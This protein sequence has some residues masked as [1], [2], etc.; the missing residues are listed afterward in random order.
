MAASEGPLID[1]AALEAHV[2]MLTNT[3]RAHGLPEPEARRIKCETLDAASAGMAL[4]AP[5][6][7]PDD[8]DD[9]DDASVVD[10]VLPQSAWCEEW[11]LRRRDLS[12]GYEVAQWD[13]RAACCVCC[14]R[15]YDPFEIDADSEPIEV[16]AE[17]LGQL[18]FANPTELSFAELDLPM[19]ALDE[20]TLYF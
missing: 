19:S 20:E 8:A 13:E 17:P 10:A 12:C 15:E 18:V 1:V 2:A 3:L 9:N 7:A 14:D 4:D 6:D 11:F 16:I 5:E